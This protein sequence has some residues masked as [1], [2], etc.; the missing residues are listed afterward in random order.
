MSLWQW[1]TG[2]GFPDG[3]LGRQIIWICT[4]AVEVPVRRHLDD[5]L[6]FLHG[7]EAEL[8]LSCIRFSA[9]S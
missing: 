7:R 3:A 9:K 6:F 2:T 5:Q 1:W 8:Y 4:A